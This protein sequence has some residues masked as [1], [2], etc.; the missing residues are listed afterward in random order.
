MARACCRGLD[1]QFKGGRW[2]EGAHASPSA[3]PRCRCPCPM[4]ACVPPDPSSLQSLLMQL[5]KLR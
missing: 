1:D 4:A 2:E 3:V 5:E